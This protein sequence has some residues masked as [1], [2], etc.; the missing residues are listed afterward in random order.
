MASSLPKLG[1][2]DIRDF[3]RDHSNRR[4]SLDTSSSRQSV[5]IRIPT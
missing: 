5:P 2:M 4:D 1:M 3:G